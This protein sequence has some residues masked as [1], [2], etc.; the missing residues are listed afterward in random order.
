MKER[1]APSSKGRKASSTPRK[2]IQR[3]DAK[4]GTPVAATEPSIADPAST[5]KKGKRL[6]FN[7]EKE[8]QKTCIKPI[9]VSVEDESP[10][11]IQEQSGKEKEK[12]SDT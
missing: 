3:E 1:E 9:S 2:K 10:K 5:R 8:N 11:A 6:A 12:I 7:S 4:E